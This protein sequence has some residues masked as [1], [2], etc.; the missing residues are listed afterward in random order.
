[1]LGLR[2]WSDDLVVVLFEFLEDDTKLAQSCTDLLYVQHWYFLFFYRHHHT[3]ANASTP[4]P[5]QPTKQRRHHIPPHTTTY[6]H[7]LPHTTTTK[8]H[9][10][11]PNTTPISS[12]DTGPLHS[13]WH[14]ACTGN[15][16]TV[17]SC[18]M[19]TCQTD[20]EWVTALAL[21][22]LGQVRAVRTQR[23]DWTSDHCH[24]Y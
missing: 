3:T 17:V 15:T 1:M 9:Q 24:C 7:L 23:A 22:S 5:T 11:P 18:M 20:K 14:E 10:T 16:K 8:H 4:T 21:W 19:R 12:T 2:A 6:Y 13:K